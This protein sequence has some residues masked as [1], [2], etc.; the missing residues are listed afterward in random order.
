MSDKNKKGNQITIYQ[1]KF[2]TMSNLRLFFCNLTTLLRDEAI[3]KCFRKNKIAADALYARFWDCGIVAAKLA[4]KNAINNVFVDSGESKIRVFQRYKKKVV[5]RHLP[6]GKGVVC[7]STK[8]LNES[9]RADLLTCMPK[10]IVLPNDIDD[11]AEAI[12]SL[13]IILSLDIRWQKRQ[14]NR[15]R[16]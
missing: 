6:F 9:K 3:Q 14:R 1:P 12:K 15:P 10:T 13:R 8:N 11:I 2:C 7:A 5:N 16:I 4:K